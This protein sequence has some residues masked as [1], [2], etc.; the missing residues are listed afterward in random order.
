MSFCGAQLSPGF[1]L[2]A[3]IIGLKEAIE[4]ADL[5]ITGEGSIVT[6]SLMGKAPAGVAAMARAAGKRVVAF[7]GR[8]SDAGGVTESFDAVLPVVDD[9]TTPEMSMEDPAGMLKNK[10]A[11]CRLMLEEWSQ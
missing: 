7:C 10:V 2:V 9:Q 8:L 6:Q 11:R 5:V 3:G 4:D 1:D